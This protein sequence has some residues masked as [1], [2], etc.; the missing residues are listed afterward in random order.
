MIKM[1]NTHCPPTQVDNAIW[2]DFTI[3]DFPVLCDLMLLYEEG[4]VET[5]EDTDKE[6]LLTEEGELVLQSYTNKSQ[7]FPSLY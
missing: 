6:K 5:Y 2:E 1:I 7:L 3:Q 4:H